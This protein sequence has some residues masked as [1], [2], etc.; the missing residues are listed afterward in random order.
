MRTKIRFFTGMN[1]TSILKKIF[2]RCSC[3]AVCRLRRQRPLLSYPRRSRRWLPHLCS[4]RVAYLTNWAI[5]VLN[6]FKS[7]YTNH[8]FI[9][10]V[11]WVPAR[12]H[13]R[14]GALLEGFG[15]LKILENTTLF[16]ISSEC[17]ECLSF[18]T[19]NLS[20]IDGQPTYTSNHL[21]DTSALYI[22]ISEP[23]IIA[24]KTFSVF[25]VL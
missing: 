11:S 18:S 9:C 13:F 15:T 14:N 19:P 7:S 2:F 4:G 21:V 17:L 10:F 23:S 12:I 1:Y 20:Y 25:H 5:C 8:I 22:H 16:L 3:L 24:I 6:H